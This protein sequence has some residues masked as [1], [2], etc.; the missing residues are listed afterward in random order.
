M[1]IPHP[2]PWTLAVACFGAG[3]MVGLLLAYLTRF[4]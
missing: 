3:V 1:R 2:D 4:L